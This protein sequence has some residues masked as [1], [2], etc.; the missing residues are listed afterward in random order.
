MYLGH[1]DVYVILWELLM[2]FFRERLLVQMLCMFL[3]DL[4]VPTV[5]KVLYLVEYFSGENAV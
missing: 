5:A 3:P 2:S 1:S 4:K